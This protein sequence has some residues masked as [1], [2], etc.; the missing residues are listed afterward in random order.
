[1][2]KQRILWMDY[3]KAIAIFL[4]VLGHS[5]NP[6]GGGQFGSKEFYLLIPYAGILLLI[7]LFVEFEG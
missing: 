5:F 4:V 7:W 2:E 1:M 3:A 6:T